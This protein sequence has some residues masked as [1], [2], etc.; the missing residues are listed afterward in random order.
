MPKVEPV[1]KYE[2]F[3]SATYPVNRVEFF[4]KDPQGNPH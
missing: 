1:A 4:S 2:T 3:E